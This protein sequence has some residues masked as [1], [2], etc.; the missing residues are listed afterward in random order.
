MYGAPASL[1]LRLLVG[2]TLVE[3]AIGEFQVQFRFQPRGEI[4][5]EGRWELRDDAGRLVDQAQAATAERDAYRV[6]QL[7][8]RKVIDA[9]VNA[10]DTAS[11][12]APVQV[13]VLFQDALDGGVE[14][15]AGDG[16]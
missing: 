15:V 13:L 4:A 5:V 12:E 9:Q 10:P 14:V 11:G 8:G 1:S 2:P 3:I 6:H 16:Q 7:L